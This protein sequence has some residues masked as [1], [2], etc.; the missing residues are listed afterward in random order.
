MSQDTT[1]TEISA[2]YFK[3]LYDDRYIGAH[4]LPGINV[5][6]VIVSTD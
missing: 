6:D 5:D 3:Q 2:T 1:S 4:I